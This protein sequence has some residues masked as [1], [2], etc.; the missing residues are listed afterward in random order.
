M[1]SSLKTAGTGKLSFSQAVKPAAVRP[2]RKVGVET[3]VATALVIS[4]SKLKV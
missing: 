4:R 3:S 2:V 1:A